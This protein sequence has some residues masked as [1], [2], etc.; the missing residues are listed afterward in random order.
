M[1]PRHPVQGFTPRGFRDPAATIASAAIPDYTCL[2]IRI[3]LRSLDGTAYFHNRTGRTTM[4]SLILLKSP[5]GAPQGQSYALT[6][7]ITAVIGRDAEQCQIVIPNSSVSRKHA[8]LS[9]VDGKVR[10]E[11]LGS[12]NGTLINQNRIAAPTL[13]KSD[14]R[15]KICDFLFKYFDENAPPKPVEAESEDDVVEDDGQTTRGTV[16]IGGSKQFLETQS[17]VEIL[18]ALFDISTG[19]SRTLEL[20]P[21]LPKIA[22]S[23]FSVFLQADRC[24]IILLDDFGRMM[25][26]VE[27]SRRGRPGDAGTRFSRTIVKRCLQSQ[28]AFLSDDAGKDE[29]LGAAQSIAEFRIRCVMCVP[30]VSAAGK[31]LGAL[32]LDTQDVS[33]KFSDDDLKLLTIVANLASIAV[34]KAQA[35]AQLLTREKERNEI[36]IARKVQIGFL[37]KSY[38]SVASYEFYGF[39][40]PAQSVGGDFYDFIMLP[41]GRVAICLGDVAGKGVAAALLMAKLSAEVR[42]CVLT[43]P[44]PA[45]AVN[46]LNNQ[47]IDGGIGDRFVTFALLLLDPIAHQVTIVNA[48]HINP[49]KLTKIGRK[50]EDAITNAQ[51]G[52]PLGLVQHCEYESIT[53]PMDMGDMFL[54]FTDGII[55]AEAPND[56][57]FNHDGIHAAVTIHCND[58]VELRPTALGDCVVR[59]AQ[60][61]MNGRAQ[62]DDIALVCFGRV[63]SMNATGS[64]L[65]PKLVEPKPGNNPLQ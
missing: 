4:P 50:F 57:R 38:P 64:V 19:L 11:D 53:V 21:L 47:L 43:Q 15:V 59:A 9:W 55:D 1:L 60:T 32:Q 24:F 54:L 44:S 20:E 37:P 61:H 3:R 56:T 12:R 23:L 63:D 65:V 35:H 29:L 46:L 31:S 6:P 18:R 51:S 13:L 30:L 27:T 34:E 8:V 33:K 36:E 49:M 26:M 17:S 22:E 48:G 14:D 42:Y 2:R 16:H 25:P 41:D 62:F 40:S 45:K 52:Y 5:G 10:V 39:Y 28:Q 58:A 7:G